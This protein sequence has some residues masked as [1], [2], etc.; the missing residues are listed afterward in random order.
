MNLARVNAP[1]IRPSTNTSIG[2]VL[3]TDQHKL[4]QQKTDRVGF[5]EN[6]YFAE[7]KRFVTDSLNWYAKQRSK[8]AEAKKKAKLAKDQEQLKEVKGQLEETIKSVRDPQ[9]QKE[10]RKAAKAAEKASENVTKHLKNDLKLYRSL[11]TA[12]TTTA[13]FSHEIS[14][15]LDEIPRCLASADRLVKSNLSDQLYTSY[16]QRTGN[17]LK[18]MDRLSHFAKLQLDLLKK[19][20][21]RN[22]V[23]HFNNVIADI[24]TNFTPLLTRENI[25]LEMYLQE[26]PAPKL[27]GATCIL[28]AIVTNCLTNS[29]RAFQSSKK[30]IEQRLITIRT[31]IDDGKLSMEI[32]D[33]GPGITEISIDDIWLPGVTTM[34]NGTGFGLTIIKDSVTDLGGSCR[35]EAIGPLGG[36]TFYFEFNTL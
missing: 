32:S 8:E 1:S 30:L 31:S 6:S 25:N 12:G 13:V 11:A 5:L 10:L 24:S 27:S 28:E 2:R 4:L 22:G 29:M 36:A 18:Y 34:E 23:I 19:D 21:R 20:K 7:L 14:K 26:Q 33:N 3:I 35:A 17:I 9:K 15:P 16:Q